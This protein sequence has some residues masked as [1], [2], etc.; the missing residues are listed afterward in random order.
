VGAVTGNPAANY[1]G[2]V[3]IFYL[4][5]ALLVLVPQLISGPACKAGY[6]LFAHRITACYSVET[7]MPHGALSND[8]KDSMDSKDRSPA[9]DGLVSTQDSHLALAFACMYGTPAA[10]H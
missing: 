5:V 1:G 6:I 2:R 9:L 8:S 4:F 10:C 3:Q 7:C